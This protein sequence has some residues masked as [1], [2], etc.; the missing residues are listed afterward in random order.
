MS[1]AWWHK[2]NN[3][4][5]TKV[6]RFHSLVTMS[7]LHN[8]MSIHSVV[9]FYFF[10]KT[11]TIDRRQILSI[12]RFRQVMNDIRCLGSLS[13]WKI[14]LFLRLKYFLFVFGCIN[15]HSYW[16]LYSSP[17]HLLYS[18]SL[19]SSHFHLYV[20]QFIVHTQ[21]TV[22]VRSMPNMPIWYKQRYFGFI[23]CLCLRYQ[24]NTNIHR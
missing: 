9:Y 22:T 14:P 16:H 12:I 3:W 19:S 13:C 21:Y 17:L 2:G 4:G 20:S 8:C 11:W 1:A 10:T 23:W 6:S 24:W 18:C 15:F 7:V 5:I